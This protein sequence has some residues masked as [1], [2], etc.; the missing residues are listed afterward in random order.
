MHVGYAWLLSNCQNAEQPHPWVCIINL[1]YK[2][3]EQIKAFSKNLSVCI[4]RILDAIMMPN[5]T[6]LLLLSPEILFDP[7]YFD[8]CEP[9]YSTLR[10]NDNTSVNHTPMCY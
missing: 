4:I 1:L 3:N 6:F 8:I 5:S 7:A 9:Q 2:L 10:N